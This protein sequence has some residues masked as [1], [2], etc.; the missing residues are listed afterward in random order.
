MKNILTV[1]GKEMTIFLRDKRTLFTTFVLPIFFYFIFFNVMAGM[2]LK[3]KKDIS[4]KTLN[5]AYSETVP[6]DIIAYLSS[7]GKKLS[8]RKTGIKEYKKML[9]DKKIQAFLNFED[10]KVVVY[11]N[12]ANRLS[13]E[14]RKRVLENL[15]TYRKEK[16]EKNL[17]TLNIPKEKIFP[18]EIDDV[19]TASKK[20]MA[21]AFLG[22]LMPYLIIIMLFSGALGFGLEVSTGEKEKGTIATL[23]VS[24]ASRTEIVLGKLFYVI[25]I[26]LLYSIVNIAGFMLASLSVSKK[27]SKELAKKAVEE[28]S[29][30]ADK[31]QQFQL[32]FNPETVL[33]LFL[34][35]IPIGIIS[36][37][38]IIAIGSYAKSM[39]EGQT[40]MTP[41]ILLIVFIAILTLN[42]PIKIPTYYFYIPVLNTAFA[43]QEI[44]TGKIILSHFLLSFGT[45]F[46]FA[47]ALVGF[48]I[49]LFNREDIHFRV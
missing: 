26:E 16:I 23:L 28:A 5:V 19:D 13:R 10:G 8:F 21:L 38:L 15:E 44:L 35:I 18:F 36:A 27:I 1:F 40:L 2:A 34:L 24:Q 17:E 12:S 30:N 22:R 46:L 42:A 25:V 47:F 11:Y 33:L 3:T 6:S 39:K 37:A 29:K 9:S 49:Y 41:V 31:I 14:A 20:D 48:S 4:E 43:M 7:N 32:S 45:T